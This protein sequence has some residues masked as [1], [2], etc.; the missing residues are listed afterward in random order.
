MSENCYLSRQDV[1][2]N[3]TPT[4]CNTVQVLFLQS[5]STCFG[6]KRPSSGVFKTGTAATGTRVIVAGKSSNHLIRAEIKPAQCCIKLV[7]YLT[8]TILHGNTKLKFSKM[9][10]FHWCVPEYSCPPGDC[11]VSTGNYSD[12]SEEDVWLGLLGL[13]LQTPCCFETKTCIYKSQLSKIPQDTNLQ[14]KWMKVHSRNGHVDPQRE[15]CIVLL[16][17]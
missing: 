4:W 9:W 6:R 15:R 1:K 2:S 8:Y 13:K 11:I 17:L 7:F 14:W 16:F 10:S 3:K 5:H 12:V